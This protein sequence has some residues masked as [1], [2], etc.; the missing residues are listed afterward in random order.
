MK[1][2]NIWRVVFMLT[3]NACKIKSILRI[4]ELFGNEYVK[5]NYPNSCI[6]YTVDNN[7]EE[8]EFFCGFQ[9]D[10]KTNEWIIFA[11][12]SV[13]RMTEQVIFLD[14]KLPNG[15]RMEQPLK[16]VRCS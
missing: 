6:A 11:R 8:Y 14:Y 9:G 12:I 15:K 10:D 7:N 5:E 2:K 16:P 4:A 1:I 13:N 3:N